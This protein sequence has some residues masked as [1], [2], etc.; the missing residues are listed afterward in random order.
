[1]RWTSKAGILVASVMME[2]IY[3]IDNS[4]QRRYKF[5]MMDYNAEKA[6]RLLK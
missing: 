5:S 6:Y 3:D 4:E 1:M 2:P